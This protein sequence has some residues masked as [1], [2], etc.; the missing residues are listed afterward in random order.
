MFLIGHKDCPRCK[1]KDV[2]DLFAKVVNELH[3][4]LVTD[5]GV[6]DADV[7][8][9]A[10]GFQI[11]WIRKLGSQ[12]HGLASSH[13][14]DTERHHHVRLALRDARRLRREWASNVPSHPYNSSRKRVPRATRSLRNP[15][16]ATAFLD[17]AKE[18]ATDKM[19]G[20][21]FTGWSVDLEG[22]LTALNAEPKPFT[23]SKKPDRAETTR[24]VAATIQAGLKKMSPPAK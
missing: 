18:N 8:R 12:C 14:P 3:E 20:V 21:L 4:H 16:S 15:E 13:R 6:R 1:D 19:L 5:K 24:G 11:D 2:G 22:L 17:V 10:L 7:E 9:S 23:L